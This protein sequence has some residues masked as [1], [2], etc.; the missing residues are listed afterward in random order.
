MAVDTFNAV[1]IYGILHQSVLKNYNH[2]GTSTKPRFI[3]TP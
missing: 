1:N 2:Y 3:K